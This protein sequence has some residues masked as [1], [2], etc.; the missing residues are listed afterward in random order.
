MMVVPFL[1]WLSSTRR[2]KKEKGK[3][4]KKEGGGCGKDT[5]RGQLISH[6]RKTRFIISFNLREERN[7]KVW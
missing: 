5:G 1:R 4:K 7:I 3:D 2:F 6:N